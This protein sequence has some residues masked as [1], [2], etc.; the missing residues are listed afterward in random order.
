MQKQSANS[1]VWIY[2]ISF[3]ISLCIF[4]FGIYQAMTMHMWVLLATGCA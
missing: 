2:W 3:V 1:V 4:G